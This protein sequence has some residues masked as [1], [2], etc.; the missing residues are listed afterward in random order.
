MT[1]RETNRESK[2][3]FFRGQNGAHVRAFTA[4]VQSFF[5]LIAYPY[6]I[7]TRTCNAYSR[8]WIDGCPLSQW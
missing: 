1:D 5:F 8:V 4:I 6:L 7:I 3:D 2:D